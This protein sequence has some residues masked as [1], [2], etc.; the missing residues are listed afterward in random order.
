MASKL[1][2][3]VT[4]VIRT[5]DERSL[6]A[7]LNSVKD[8][9]EHDNIIV[10]KEKPFYRAVQKTFEH[11]INKGRKWTLAVDADL[12]LL[13]QA[14]SIMLDQA[15]KQLELLYVYQGFILDKF[16]CGKRQGGPHL[17]RTEHLQKALELLEKDDQSLRPES[18]TYKSM[19]GL[20][21]QVVLDKKVFALHDFFQSFSDVYRKAYFHGIKHKGWHTLLPLWIQKSENDTDYKIA[22]LGF[23][24]GYFSEGSSYPSIDQFQ[25]KVLNLLKSRFELKEK[26]ELK[27]EDLGDLRKYLQ[28]YNINYNSELDILTKKKS[29]MTKVKNKLFK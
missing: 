29:L 2:D 21:Y 20:G 17:Y 4:V 6:N 15:E 19:A 16:K 5:A 24:D 11:G 3:D 9:V 25:E 8:Q 18:N 23:I 13:P 12:V 28:E 27:L 10:I 1:K 22:T 7:C 26:D 14:I